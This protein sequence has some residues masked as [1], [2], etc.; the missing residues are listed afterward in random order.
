MR[1]LGRG[2]P[3]LH[4]NL[5]RVKT[6]PHFKKRKEEN[7]RDQKERKL[8]NLSINTRT[9]FQPELKENG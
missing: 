9:T 7:T 4:V 3:K 5:W 6:L 8:V 1:S 2:K